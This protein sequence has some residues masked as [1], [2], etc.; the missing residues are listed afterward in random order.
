MVCKAR[1]GRKI[2]ISPLISIYKLLNKS[3]VLKQYTTKTSGTKCSALN[4]ILATQV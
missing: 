2:Q 3:K 4:L 1:N